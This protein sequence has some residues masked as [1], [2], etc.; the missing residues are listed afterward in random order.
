MEQLEI[1]EFQTQGF[2]VKKLDTDDFLSSD[3][4]NWSITLCCCP[5]CCCCWF[6]NLSIKHYSDSLLFN[7]IL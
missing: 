2:E 7:W 1:S 5:C 4:M 3:Q 6:I